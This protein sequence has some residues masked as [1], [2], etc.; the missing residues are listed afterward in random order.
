MILQRP[1]LPTL[2]AGLA[3]TLSVAAHAQTAPQAVVK[4]FMDGFNS[5]NLAKSAALNSA[6]GTSIIE[7]FAPYTWTGTG[8]FDHWSADYDSN[9]KAN[10]ITDG[11][12][13]LSAPLV[14]SVTETQ[15][16]LIYPSLYLYKQKG[17]PMREPGRV[18][19]VLRKEGSDWKI[20][21]WTWTGTVPTRAK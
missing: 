12:V 9:A 17:T 19:M 1:H 11:K 3:F 7:R 21:A 15:A 13:T 10:G 8:A 14:Q 4:A 5:G 20:A 6:S 18:A 16:Y 2:F